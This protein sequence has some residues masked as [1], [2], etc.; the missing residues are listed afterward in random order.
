[1]ANNVQ[2]DVLLVE[3][4]TGWIAQGLQFD[5]S[6]QADTLEDVMYAFERAV[7][8]HQAAAIAQGIE[9]F[10]GLPPAPQRC[11]DR[12]SSGRRLSFEANAPSFR[13]DRGLSI[14]HPAHDFRLARTA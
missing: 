12:W 2:I 14:P 9:P 10:E 4:E 1:M 5:I 3:D 8:G 7:V 6:A 13:V 11:W